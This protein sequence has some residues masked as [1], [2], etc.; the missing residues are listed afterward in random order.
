MLSLSLEFP[1]S[2]PS[3]SLADFTLFPGAT[4][5]FL[6]LPPAE[7]EV[8]DPYLNDDRSSMRESL[9]TLPDSGELLVL[10]EAVV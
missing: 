5:S 3:L 7:A 1:A 2:L 6:Y 4:G 10:G 9:S 8:C